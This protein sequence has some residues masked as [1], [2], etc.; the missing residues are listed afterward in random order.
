MNEKLNNLRTKIDA[1]DNQIILLLNQR[2]QVVKEIGELKQSTKT[3]I[4]RPEREKAIINRLCKNPANSLNAKAV[5]AIF[6]EIFAVSRNL[7]KP[8]IVAFLGPVGTHTHQAAQSRFGGIGSYTPLSSIE[9][10]FKEVANGEAKFGVIPVENNTEGAVGVTLDCLAKFSE[11]KIV[12]E[13]YADIHHSL[14]SFC[15][16]TQEIKKI[17]SHPQAYNQC[18]EFLESHGLN[19]VEF[20]P[21]KST[22]QAALLAKDDPQSAAIC[23]KIAANLNHI[24]LLF[25]TIEDN[26]SNRTR[27]FVISDFKNA[28]TKES[29][30]SILAKTPHKSGSLAEFLLAF[31]NAG[32]NLLKLESRPLKKRAFDAVFYIDFSGHID[33]ENVAKVLNEAK[34]NG[35]MIIWLGS[36]LGEQ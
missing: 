24:P 27:F 1:I 19:E 34:N 8:E 3:A 23:S 30:T 10:V 11:V 17:Y 31:K 25:E 33:D 22:A 7:E 2:M 12:A 21:A 15:E 13:I 4:Y 28:A 6:G 26:S 16:K 29:K 14:A 36:Y 35:Y 32:I 18:R 20:V 9:A 5:E